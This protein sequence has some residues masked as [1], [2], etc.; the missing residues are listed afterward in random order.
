[1]KISTLFISAMTVLLAGAATAGP[2]HIDFTTNNL[3]STFSSAGITVT[4]TAFANTG[5]GGVLAAATLGRYSL[6]LGVCNT[7]EVNC[8]SPD[9]QVDNSRQLDFVLFTFS[10]PVNSISFTV[11][12]AGNYDT[13]VTWYSR[14]LASVINITGSSLSNL[15]SNLG[16]TQGGDDKAGSGAA[17]TFTVTGSG[18][19]SVLLGAKVSGNTDGLDYFKIT[20][21]DGSIPSGVTPSGVPEPSTMALLG[22]ALCSLGL[23]R[24]FQSSRS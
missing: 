22:G 13:D 9:H 11:T 17:H 3:S 8:G 4:P 16:Y 15:T 1:M 23:F 6:G 21:M 7:Q 2:I 24:R 19:T 10:G 5:V 20:S 14:T 12:P 18:I